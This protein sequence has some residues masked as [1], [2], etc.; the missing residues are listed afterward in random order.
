[1]STLPPLRLRRNEDRRIRAGH[2]WIFSNEVD[3]DH[4]PLTGFEPGQAV[5]VQDHR[6]APL[7]TAYVNPRTLIAARLVSREAGRPLDRGLLAERVRRARALREALF[8]RPF[9]RLV[10][11][12]GDGLPGLVVDR[13]GDLL[14]AQVTTAGMERVRGELVDVLREELAPRGVLLRGDAPGRRLEGLD[15]YVETAWGEVP[16]ALP[17]EENGTR[18]EAPV[19]GQKT[20]WF[21]DHRLNRARM[22]SYVP[23]RRVLDLFS[24]VGGWGVQAAAAGAERVLCVDS[25]AEA[26][27]WAE[28]NARLNGVGERVETRRGDAFDVLRALA[29]GGERFGAVILDPPAFVKRK[30]DL[31]KGEEAYR[32]LTLAAL[33]VLE[34][35]G[36]LVSA[37]CSFHFPREGLRDALRRAGRKTG[38]VVQITEQGGQ[39]PDH[40]VHPAIPETAYLKVVFARVG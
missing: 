7:G 6:G 16:D 37:S 17:V 24:Y 15:E 29:A 1:M 14:V 32:R 38:R 30:K 31:R 27:E 25:S 3:V 2:L 4:T 40:P 8:D 36:F 20:G 5:E 21:Y 22:R 26:L 19:G 35:D 34:P 9:H 13:Y 12:E 23:G 33:E 28:R 18:F 10:Y 11:G 39:G